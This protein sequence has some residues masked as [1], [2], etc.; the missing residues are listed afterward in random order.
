MSDKSNGI[1]LGRGIPVR[2]I[3]RLSATLVLVI[4][5]CTSEETPTEPGSVGNPAPAAPSP[6]LASNTWTAKPPR[7]GTPLV[8]SSAGVTTN[9]A[10]QSVVYVFGGT[11]GAGGSG[12]PTSAYDVSTNTWTGLGSDVY[13]FHSNGV[14]NIGGKL[15][16]SGGNDYGT[17][18]LTTAT[19]VWA[20]DPAANLLTK[21]ADMPKATAEG[22]TGVINDKLYVLPGLCSGDLYPDP[23][24]CAEEP[25]RQLY[26]YNP[27]ANTWTKQRAAPHFHR[28]GAAGVIGGKL[29]VAGGFINPSF[30]P[31]TALDVY[32]PAT[33]TWV[34]RASVP[35]AGAA[36]GTAVQG[37][38]F[39]I[40]NSGTGLKA[41]LYD[42]AVNTW[43]A[44]AAPTWGHDA[45]VKVT[46][47][48]H[49]ALLGVGGTHGADGDIPNDTELYTP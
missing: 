30:D 10:G 23:R 17:G 18:T 25:I 32:D 26:R 37:K 33:N 11:D 49:P 36:I 1:S 39:V 48:G 19:Q 14:G 29:Y 22:V 4:S 47:E 9:A 35:T 45:L 34:T 7:P 43:K 42:P 5:A 15:Y 40:V 3:S 13:V 31:T 8:G 46:F 6:A 16:F 21:K 24:Y 2:L 20:Y 44:R 38:L 27:A 28:V 12:F 41:Y